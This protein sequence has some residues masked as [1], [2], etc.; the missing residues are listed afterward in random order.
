MKI[1]TVIIAALI[2]LFS[3]VTQVGAEEYDLSKVYNSLSDE[4]RQSMQA[5]GADSADASA[6][7]DITPGSIAGE[8]SRLASEQA[9]APLKALINIT[10]ILLIA[11]ML[12]AYKNTLSQEVGDT[13]NTASALCISCAVVSPAVGLIGQAQTVIV[14]ASNLMLAYVP[15]M[16]VLLAAGGR[17]V[18]SGSYYASVLLTGEGVSSLCSKVVVPFLNLFLGLSIVSGV[19]PQVN[20][21]GLTSLIS[22]LF[23]WLMGFAMA[24]FTSVTG[25]RGLLSDSLDTVSGRA[26]RFAVSSFIPVV[27]SALADAYKTVQGSMG[28]LKSGVGVFVIIAVAFTFLPVLLQSML[29]AA[30]LWVGRLTAEALRLD[31]AGKLLDGLAAVFSTVIALLLCVMTIFIISTAV[32]LLT[33][34]SS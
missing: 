18:G 27:G 4:A 10:A 31:R 22:K 3:S 13:L 17:A 6:L 24:V 11:A 5:I 30:A 23:K 34:G 1:L 20:L 33:G 15:I 25:L 32:V 16:A 9:S 14:S 28:L 7:S 21:S 19:T 26:V 12:C 8:I 29:W 2:L